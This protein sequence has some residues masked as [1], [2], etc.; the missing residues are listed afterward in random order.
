[1]ARTFV[2]GAKLTE[3]YDPDTNE[4]NYGDRFKDDDC[5][6]ILCLFNNGTGN[7]NAAA[8]QMLAGMDSAYSHYE[9]TNDLDDGDAVL[10]RP[11]GQMMAAPSDA[12]G[13]WCQYKGPTRN[14]LTTD[15]NVAEG[16]NMILVNTG[17]GTV[18]PAAGV[19]THVGVALAADSG[20][21]LAAG[22]AVLNINT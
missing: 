1:M 3:A 14:A 7:E 20:T 17:V 8:G 15:G 6:F 13:V 12:E 5:E 9:G 19:V 10:N 22:S 16:N 11:Y 18:G 2:T 4:F 21:T